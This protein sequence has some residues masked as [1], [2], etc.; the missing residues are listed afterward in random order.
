MVNSPQATLHARRSPIQ[1]AAPPAR[2]TG[3]LLRIS[4]PG[5][6][7]QVL[8]VGYA[9]MIAADLTFALVPTVYGELA[10]PPRQGCMHC[11]LLPCPGALSGALSGASCAISGA[12]AV[13]CIVS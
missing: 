8:L 6:L 2:N 10:P 1:S 3:S 7:R 4:G 12:W 5:P 9:A 13:Q 11:T